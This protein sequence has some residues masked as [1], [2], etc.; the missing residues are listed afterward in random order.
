[1]SK[2]SDLRKS[3]N[4]KGIATEM[5][6]PTE[7]ISTGNAAMNF[8][9]TGRYD[10]GLPNKRSLLLWGESG[11]GKTFLA[12]NMV[13]A[14]QD[15]GYA[16]VYLDSEDSISEDYMKKI[17]IDLSEDMFIPVLV[18]TIEETTAAI[19]E[20]F[21]TMGENDKFMLVIDSLAGLL[22]E[23]EEGEFDKGQAKG[24]QG[25][26]A[27][28]LKLMV[29]NINRKI[30]DR[31]AFCIM[32]THA[33]QNQD[34]Y[35]SEKWICSGGKGMQF[36]PSFSIRLDKAKLKDESKK[37]INGVRIKGEV[38]KTR[39]TAPFQKFEL[40]VPYDK[41]LDFTDGL[42]DI[43]EEEG[44]VQKNGAWYNY[45][46]QGETVKFQASKFE[47]HYERIME[48]YQKELQESYDE[49]LEVSEE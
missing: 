12:S 35:S 30:S 42:L 32:V 9:M 11:T 7:W 3:L 22:S 31:D 44:I 48:N 41:G 26:I 4:K 18:D 45:Q 46:Y 23:K 17:N 40:D 27:K 13:K 28:R 10:I 37:V 8:R 15:K 43:L 16:I 20:I 19:A 21:T 29:K 33:Y 5:N 34:M 25:Q 39:F 38:T 47:D 1:M 2:A 36:F 49:S 24:D 14:A 6:E